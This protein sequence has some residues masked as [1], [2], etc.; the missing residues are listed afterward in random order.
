MSNYEISM[1]DVNWGVLAQGLNIASGLILLPVVLIYL[2]VEEVG[3]WFVFSSLTGLAFLLELGLQPSIARYVAY[4]YAGAQKLQKVGISSDENNKS[5]NFN[6]L[7]DVF[8]SAKKIYFRITILVLIFL[9]GL[10][11]LY[12]TSLVTSSLSLMTVLLA[13]MMFSIGFIANFY[14]GYYIAFLQ[15]RGEITIANKII[16]TNRL[17]MISFGSLFLILGYGLIGLGLASLLSTVLSRF[18]LHYMFWKDNTP[19]ALYLKRI[20]M[21]Y[22]KN[23]SGVLWHNSVKL[24]W[25]YVGA[26]LITRMNVLI[27][28]SFLGL[29]IAASYG[30]TMQI[31]IM[32]STLA[33]TLF[34]LKLPS[35]NAAQAIGKSEKILM[36]FGQS[37]TLS[38]L[39]YFLAA[40]FIVMFGNDVL[41]YFGSNAL[42][43]E[44][45]LLIAFSVIMFLE[46]NHSLCASFLTTFNEV[47]FVASALVSGFLIV[48]LSMIFVY[49]LE[50]GIWG[51]ILSQG[52][53]QLAYNN[54][55]WPKAAAEK[56]QVSFLS[57]LYIGF[58]N[59]FNHAL[60]SIKS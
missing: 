5:I 16:V 46:M 57:L 12:I 7:G 32:L 9:L 48:T 60:R 35:M 15:G 22:D 31:L 42:L 55:K 20:N 45:N 11:S 49:V 23:T 26:F 2:S 34:T 3:L 29:T 27:A 56:I 44:N 39:F 43:L 18:L 54:W 40:A 36:S 38:W 59:I 53:V 37:L 1:R 52:F 19:E 24:G 47:S 8:L 33:S 28:S 25:V 30:L 13:W 10:G 41:K 21:I 58:S 17:L 14:F 4:I 50:F 51:L 6:L